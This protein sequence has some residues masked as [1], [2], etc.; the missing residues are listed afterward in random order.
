M[1]MVT[2]LAQPIRFIMWN[3]PNRSGS[4]LVSSAHIFYKSIQELIDL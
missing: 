1:D 2:N 4:Q 3:L